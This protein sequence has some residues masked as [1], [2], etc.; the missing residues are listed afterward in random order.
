MPDF[1]QE[2]DTNLIPVAK[3]AYV[4]PLFES[5]AFTETESDARN[6]IGAAGKSYVDNELASK[7]DLV[8]GSVPLAQIPSLTA[9]K[10][11]SGTFADARIPSTVARTANVYSKAE[12]NANISAL[13]HEIDLTKQPIGGFFATQ[14]GGAVIPTLSINDLAQGGTQSFSMAWIGYRVV[15]DANS[16]NPVFGNTRGVASVNPGS[17]AI[18]VRNNTDEVR[19][20]YE[21]GSSS[22]MSTFFEGSNSSVLGAY[23][24]TFSESTKAVTLYMNGV[25]TSVGDWS[26]ATLNSTLSLKLMLAT[27]ASDTIDTPR[28]PSGYTFAAGAWTRELTPSEVAEFSSSAGKVMPLSARADCVLHLTC[29][30]GAGYQLRDRSGNGNHALLTDTG[31]DHLILRDSGKITQAAANY[32]D[33]T[34][35]LGDRPILP[36]NAYVTGL[37]INGEILSLDSYAQ[38]AALRQ[39][40]IVDGGGGAAWLQRSNGTT[41]ETLVE[42]PHSLTGLS[43]AL[44]W[45]VV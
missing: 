2:W 21:E 30:D 19:V 23:V 11:T 1:D 44:T 39:I 20:I 10:T 7:A 9:A 40:R 12:A 14:E 43:I 5:L 27:S 41:H 33:G 24:L 13:R 18:S 3:G 31:T 29:D 6:L 36:T 37:V 38:S 8:S 28:S 25:Q 42:T 15:S 32:T 26:G 22:F 16:H 45:E 34:Y 17:A 4:S 35:L